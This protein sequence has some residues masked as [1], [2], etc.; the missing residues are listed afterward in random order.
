MICRFDGHWFGDCLA[1]VEYVFVGSERI[2]LDRECT[3]TIWLDL[4]CPYVLDPLRSRYRF[5]DEI[6]VTNH[7]VDSS[8]DSRHC[9]GGSFFHSILELWVVSNLRMLTP[10]P[11]CQPPKS[12]ID[13]YFK[14]FLLIF[15]QSIR[16]LPQFSANMPV[17]WNVQ[18]GIHI[19]AGKGIPPCRAPE[20]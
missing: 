18:G 15:C 17:E 3:S 9:K 7:Q 1:S 6:N 10:L 19:G 16:A 11:L 2:D 12:F 8:I 5:S 13:N 20:R 14:A 4:H